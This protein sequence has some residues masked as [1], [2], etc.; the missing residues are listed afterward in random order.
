MRARYT[1]TLAP[2]TSFCV[3]IAAFMRCSVAQILVDTLRKMNLHYPAARPS[4]VGNGQGEE[5]ASVR[6]VSRDSAGTAINGYRVR[7]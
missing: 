5:D 4:E 2:Q 1:D 6:E 3:S 7:L